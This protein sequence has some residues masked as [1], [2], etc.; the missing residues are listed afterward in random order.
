MK[1][2][3]KS[4]RV[5]L[6]DDHEILLDGLRQILIDSFDIVGSAVNGR[7]LVALTMDQKPDVIVTDI[8]MPDMTG[9][10]AVQQIR[11]M[12]LSP[13]VVFLTMLKDAKLAMQAFDAGGTAAG[14]VLKNSAG[15]ELVVAIREVLAGRSYITPRIASDLLRQCAQNAPKLPDG[16]TARQS[17][18]LQ[19]I[20]HGKTM[21]E[22]AAVLDISTRTAEAHKYQMM[23]HLGFKTTAQLI[24]FAVQQGLGPLP[25]AVTPP[26]VDCLARPRI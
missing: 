5:A 20:A 1:S 15:N 19:L 14:Y 17:E 10:D 6:A 13:R 24:R 11:K 8:V 9:I 26:P 16:L 2:T 21:K 12:G 7:E 4:I 3:S 25:T 22:V 23:E 18:V